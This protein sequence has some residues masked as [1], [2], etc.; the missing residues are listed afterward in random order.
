MYMAV[1]RLSWLAALA[2]LSIGTAAHAAEETAARRAAPPLPREKPPVVVGLMFDAGVPDGANGA[3]VLA[4]Q[5]L[6]VHLGGGTNTV[7]AGLRGGFTVVPFGAGPSLSMEVGHYRDG[8]AN[9]IVRTF[10]GTD[11]WLTPIFQ[12]LGYTYGN[13][14]LGLELGR[15]PVQFFVHAGMSYLKATIHNANAALG[16]RADP[17]GTR[18]DGTTVTIRQDPTVRVIS[19]SAKLGMVVYLGDR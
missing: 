14:Q 6:R 11:G 7:S 1:Q 9:G 18:D 8:N 12:Q 19:P 16:G 10:A 2:A 3:I 13:L 17:D 4:A 5:R 15:G